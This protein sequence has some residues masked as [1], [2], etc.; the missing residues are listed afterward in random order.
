MCLLLWALSILGS[1]LRIHLLKLHLATVLS[2]LVTRPRTLGASAEG[3]VLTVVI[4]SIEFNEGDT[5]TESAQKE[6]ALS[7]DHLFEDSLGRS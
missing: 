3:L 1:C 6:T 5:I 7:R 2:F 4:D